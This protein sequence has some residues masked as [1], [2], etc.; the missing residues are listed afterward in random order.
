MNYPDLPESLLR[1]EEEI[2]GLWSEEDLFQQTMDATRGGDP[3]VF[4]EG[5]LLRTGGRGYTIL[6]PGPSKIWC[7][8]IG[9]CAG[10]E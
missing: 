2:L 7:A 8:G 4:Y 5:R 6:S 1:L 3:F 9:R 10:I